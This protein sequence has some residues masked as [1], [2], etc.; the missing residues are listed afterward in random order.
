MSRPI[1]KTLSA[2]ALSLS[3][4]VTAI[5][6]PA[7]PARA[8]DAEDVAGVLAGLAALYIIGR[9]IDDRN[10]RN[11]RRPQVSRNQQIRNLRIAPA[12]C[13]REFRA[14]N[15]RSVRG[16]GARCMQN[17]V[18]RPGIL[19][20]ECIRNVSTNRGGRFIYGGRCLA[21]N[22]WRRESFRH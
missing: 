10:D 8:A 15:G 7:T 12:A 17:R 11:T 19:P 14:S 21:Q 9:A 6:L 18:A 2:V 20:P 22:G 13:F 4:A 3:L 1:Q 16:Y 5:T